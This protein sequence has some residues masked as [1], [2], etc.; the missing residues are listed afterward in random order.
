MRGQLEEASGKGCKRRVMKQEQNKNSPEC[1]LDMI[2]RALG[3][4][5][6]S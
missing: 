6:H 1:W 5:L 4:P 2:L 3:T